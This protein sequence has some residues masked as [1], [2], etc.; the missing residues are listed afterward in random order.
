MRPRQLCAPLTIVALIGSLV[1]SQ[2]GS[3]GRVLAQDQKNDNPPVAQKPLRVQTSLVNLFATVRDS[4]HALVPNL[5]KDDFHIFEDGQEQKVAFFSKEMNLP[6]TLGLLIDTSGSEQHMLVAEEDAMS[7]FV[8]EVLRKKDM[9]MVLSFDTD[10][11]LL[12]DFTEDTAMLERAIRRAQ[13]NVPQNMGMI[14]Q[15]PVPQRQV[16]S[17]ALY[18]AI[19]LACGEKLATEAGRKALVIVTDAQDEGSKLKI[20]D[21]IEAAQRAD[22][23][24]HIILVADPAFSGFGYIGGSAAKKLAEE[25]DG[26]VIEVRSEKKLVEAFQQISEEL[27]SQYTLGYYPSNQMRDGGFRK[28]KV[29]GTR[30]GLKVLARRGYYAPKG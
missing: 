25:T 10:V 5:T 30:P 26:R 12:A 8:H 15:G 11:D 6:I 24:I 13:I 16:T 27:R 4:H 9:A 19:Y 2:A 14:G 23:V 20:Q 21:A 22:T 29:E 17:T 7:R 28:I 18:D 1:M 3:A